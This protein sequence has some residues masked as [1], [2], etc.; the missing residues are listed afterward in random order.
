MT[1][2]LGAKSIMQNT[3][4]GFESKQHEVDKKSMK[5]NIIEQ[6]KKHFNPEFINRLDEMIVFEPLD[7]KDLEKILYLQTKE[8]N[9]NLQDIGLSVEITKEFADWIISKEYKKEYGARSLRRAIQRHI[10]DMLAEKLINKELKDV[11]KVVIDVKNDTPYIKSKKKN[12]KKDKKE[13]VTT[14]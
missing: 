9:K 11:A 1:S 13:V 5:K 2:N 10:E 8:I 4:L 12:T 14:K 3:T 7:E 6:V